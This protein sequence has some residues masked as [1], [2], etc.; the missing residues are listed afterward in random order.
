[1]T[2]AK[3]EKEEVKATDDKKIEELVE[4]AKTD[5][6][7]VELSNV[8]GEDAGEEAEAV[9]K[10][11]YENEIVGIIRG[12]ASPRVLK[13]KLDDYHEN[14]IAN[15]LS[16][17]KANERQKLFRVLDDEDL[18]EIF[19]YVEKEDAGLYI[20]EMDLKKAAT[21]ISNLEPDTAIEVL[22][23]LEKDK[24]TLLIDSMESDV[25]HDIKMVASFDEDEIGSEMTT[26]CIIIKDNLDIKNAMKE[27][28]KQAKENDNIQTIF[29][30]DEKG[31]FYGAID[32]KE[33]IIA[34]KED[35][36]KDLIVTSFPY[37]YGHENTSE[38][39]DKLREYSEP[40]IPVLDN[41]N[42]MLGVITSQSLVEV[43]DD[44]LSEDYVKF[45]GLTAEEDLKEPLHESMS[46]RLPWLIVLL[47]LGLF[48]SSVVGIYEHVIQSLT[49]IM[50]F[51]SLILDMAG[52]AGTQSLAVTIRV[53]TDES[54]SF[55]KKAAFVFKEI[56]VG[57]CNGLL[58]GII[59]FILIGLYICILKQKDA[60]FAFA[61]SGCIGLSLVLSMIISSALGTLIPMFFNKIKVDPA[62]ASGPLI[63][64]INDLVAVVTYYSMSAFLLL[65]V[66]HLA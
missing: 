13:Q 46:K 30:E 64:T 66:L 44:E 29:V 8:I 9:E 1:M 63:T 52:N 26:N 43:V 5:A 24:R 22:K 47:G 2:K 31:E 49:I 59:S 54:L 61:V 20:N 28:V 7:V 34:R 18:A 33:M 53:L 55:G 42:R 51:Q 45:A 32:L 58:L 6:E 62:V 17:L 40:L 14:N 38:C 36:L 4:K 39:I 50:A 15:A 16:L 35:N 21:L 57:F 12:N 27:L 3:E 25:R 56:R 41:K 65:K 37:V 60:S 19:E 10:P 11:D 48:V 23:E